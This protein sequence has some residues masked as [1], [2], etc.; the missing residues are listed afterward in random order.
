MHKRADAALLFYLT[1]SISKAERE[2]FGIT[3]DFLDQPSPLK[4]FLSL[5]PWDDGT[6][7][8][9]SSSE[10][11]LAEALESRFRNNNFMLHSHLDPPFA[12]GAFPLASRTLNHSCTPN[13]VP[14]FILRG[15]YP[16]T[17]EVIAISAI[18]SEEEVTIPYHDPAIPVKERRQA[19]FTNYNFNCSCALCVWSLDSRLDEESST[20]ELPRDPSMLQS[21]NAAVQEFSLPPRLSG[22]AWLLSQQDLFKSLPKNLVPAFNPSYLPA[23][24]EAFSRASHEGDKPQDGLEVGRTLLALYRI[25]YPPGFPLNGLHALELCKVVWNAVCIGPSE[26]SKLTTAQ[27]RLWEE[28]M[29]ESARGYLSVAEGVLHCYGI[30][31]DVGGPIAEIETMRKLLVK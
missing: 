9:R 27:V 6:D 5:L 22:E 26:A 18:R 14:K 11:S 19:L 1:H 24:S 30:E 25:I 31:G 3:V 15:G 8:H 17:M 10:G 29:L 21:F 13:A 2:A 4:I 20:S 16:P 12:H 7:I 23:L 28:K